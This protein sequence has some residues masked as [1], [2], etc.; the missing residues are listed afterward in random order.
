[1]RSAVRAAFTAYSKKM[2]VNPHHN[3]I[4]SIFLKSN[5]G[6]VEILDYLLK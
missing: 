5:I 3:N 4:L 1:L 2:S 6:V